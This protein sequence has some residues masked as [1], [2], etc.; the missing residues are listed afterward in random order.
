MVVDKSD[1]QEIQA[2]ARADVE[3]EKAEAAEAEE[4]PAAKGRKR[5]GE[6]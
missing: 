5:K 2:A 6:A 3:R 4:K 1:A